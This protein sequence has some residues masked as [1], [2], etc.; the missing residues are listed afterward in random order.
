MNSKQFKILGL[1]WNKDYKKGWIEK[2]VGMIVTD[3]QWQKL[4]K[5]KT[6]NPKQKKLKLDMIQDNEN[7]E[8]AKNIKKGKKMLDIEQYRKK[9]KCTFAQAVLACMD[10]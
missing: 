5:A 3:E 1:N 7:M 6:K 2:L 9:H 10:L 8:A 4:L